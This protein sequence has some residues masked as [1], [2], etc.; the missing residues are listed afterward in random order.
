MPHEKANLLASGSSNQDAQANQHFASGLI[1]A[2]FCT[3]G[4]VSSVKWF[5]CFVVVAEGQVRLYDDEQTFLSNPGNFVQK[6][7][8]T[9]NHQ[10]SEIK[11]KAYSQNGTGIVEFSCF[12]VQID[13]G[14]FFPTK[15]LKIG[16][17]SPQLAESLAK[18]VNLN[19][20]G[21]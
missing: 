8:L 21:I 15:Q 9:R 2:K 1:A 17:V 14:V 18:C 5:S 4:Y 12:Y 7:Y 11:R 3:F 13:N 16:C 6:I 19:A 10:A 20:R